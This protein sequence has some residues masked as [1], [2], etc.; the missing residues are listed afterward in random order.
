METKFTPNGANIGTTL[1]VYLLRQIL[2]SNSLWVPVNFLYLNI[3]VYMQIIASCPSLF[4]VGNTNIYTYIFLFPGEVPAC[5]FCCCLPL[6][7]APSVCPRVPQQTPRLRVHQCAQKWCSS[8]I[9][10]HTCL[11]KR[12][13]SL[14]RTTCVGCLKTLLEITV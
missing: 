1:V 14:L 6:H 8:I 13:S 3:D 7:T 4:T 5:C 10:S 9:C 11:G 2:F 12:C